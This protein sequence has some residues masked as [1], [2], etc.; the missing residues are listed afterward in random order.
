MFGKIWQEITIF[1]QVKEN[2]ANKRANFSVL[3]ILHIVT[4]IEVTYYLDSRLDQLAAT[5]DSCPIFLT[6]V[7]CRA[8]GT[9]QVVGAW[10]PCPT[11]LTVQKREQKQGQGTSIKDV[12]SLLPQQIYWQCAPQFFD[13]P[14]SLL[15][16]A[17]VSLSRLTVSSK[18]KGLI[19][20]YLHDTKMRK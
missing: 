16:I 11:I 9:K 19:S 1:S 8:D 12:R 6:I 20:M 13:L 10:C 7:L 2:F 14:S 5:L 3:K 4:T 17:L 18:N 15:C